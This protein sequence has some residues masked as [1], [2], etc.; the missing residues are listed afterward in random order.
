MIVST[1]RIAILS[2]QARYESADVR[3]EVKVAFQL[4]GE[5]LKAVDF[6]SL[7]VKLKSFFN[8]S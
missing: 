7:R 8:W 3:D 2:E 5:F 6:L 1:L 4:G